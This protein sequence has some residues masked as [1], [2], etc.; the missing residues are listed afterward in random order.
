MNPEKLN[1]II[2]E[3]VRLAIMSALAA[4]GKLTFPEL[5]DFLEVTDGNLSV[6]SR[7]LEE[8]GLISVKKDYVGRKPRTTFSITGEGRKQF[9]KYI[10][11]LEE[12]IG[13]E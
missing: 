3:R 6:H 8:G 9:R 1:K 11:D 13:K 7:I 2:H 12:M 4:R 10:E 5:K